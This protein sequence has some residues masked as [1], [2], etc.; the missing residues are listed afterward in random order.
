L[1]FLQEQKVYHAPAKNRTHELSFNY[2]QLCWE[3]WIKLGRRNMML[4]KVKERFKVYLP[5]MS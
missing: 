5:S 3:S 1:K 2:V 4:S